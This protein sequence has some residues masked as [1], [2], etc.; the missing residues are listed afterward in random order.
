VDACPTTPVDM[1]HLAEPQAAHAEW[2]RAAL[3]SAGR[4]G[5]PRPPRAKDA[6]SSEYRRTRVD[7]GERSEVTRCSIRRRR[8]SWLRVAATSSDSGQVSRRRR[9]TWRGAPFGAGSAISA[10]VKPIFW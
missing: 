10:G 2:R 1:P 5:R 4:S 8:S 6:S 7:R 3:W 9:K